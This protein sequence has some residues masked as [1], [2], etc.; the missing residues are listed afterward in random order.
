MEDVNLWRV[1]G[2][3]LLVVGG[4]LAAA[5]LARRYNLAAR[6]AG[7]GMTSAPAQLAVVEQLY[8]DQRRRLVLVRRGDVGHV[9]MLGVNGEQVVETGIALPPMTQGGKN[10]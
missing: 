2:A 4:I 5:A 3:F 1:L 6:F 8:L 7:V 10:A 9:L